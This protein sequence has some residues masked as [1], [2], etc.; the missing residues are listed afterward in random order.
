ML[1]SSGKKYDLNTLI[2]G[3]QGW[4]LL[5]ATGIG[6]NG[7]VVGY[8]TKTQNDLS[9][10]TRGFLL[11]PNFSLQPNTNV[12]ANMTG[13]TSTSA[14]AVNIDRL[15]GIDMLVH[16]S[17]D[18]PKV[19]VPA[20]AVIPAGSSSKTFT[21]TV[22][23][24]ASGVAHITASL[25]GVTE[26][27]T[28]NLTPPV[29]L[30]VKTVKFVPAT[31]TATDSSTC[32]ITLTGNAPA[33]GTLVNLTYTDPDSSFGSPTPSSVLVLAGHNSVSLVYNTVSVDERE[34][35]SVNAAVGSQSPAISGKLTI[36]PIAIV[37]ISITPNPV[38]LGAGTTTATVTINRPAPAG[39]LTI[40]MHSSNSAK[41]DFTAGPTVGGT[42]N[43]VIPQ[44]A[45]SIHVTIYLNATGSTTIS[46][47][48]PPDPLEAGGTRKSVSLS[49]T[50]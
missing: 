17:S 50:P 14:S 12:P 13:G 2:S 32:T 3:G 31:V 34:S 18:N 30:K 38:S 48:M 40:Q 20:G 26:T 28:I 27:S 43:V 11:T 46:A 41:A 49:I 6:D 37:S 4:Q 15:I 5:E 44:G 24:G 25:F 33:G 36:N 8:G 22:D 21:I 9:V 7:Y 19:H 39:G 29:P 42:V 45:T 10:P 23:A 16:L 35:P 1:V 47:Q